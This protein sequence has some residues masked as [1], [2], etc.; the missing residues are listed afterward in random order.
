MSRRLTVD[1]FRVRATERANPQR[2]GDFGDHR[3][4]PEAA[5]EFARFKWRDAAVLIPVIDRPEAP[6][7]LLTQRAAHLRT[8]SGQIAFPGGRID[9]EDRDA[10]TAAL[11]ECE[12]ETGIAAEHVEI[13]GRLPHYMAGSGFRIAPIL[14]VVRP[15]F[16]LAPNPEE[17][18]AVFEVPLAFLMDEANHARGSRIVGGHLRHYFEMPYGDWYIWGV[19]AGIIRAM[20]ERL[21]S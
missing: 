6:S 4:N 17:V 20:Y 10:E 11:R 1:D 2:N 14:S 7:V 15:G 13:V 5:K 3:L 18:E 16:S 8:H 19:T 9:P 12:E 21:Y